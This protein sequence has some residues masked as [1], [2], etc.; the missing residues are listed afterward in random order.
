MEQ[1]VMSHITQQA[2]D[3]C[4]VVIIIVLENCVEIEVVL[5]LS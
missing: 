1:V 3:K 4:V 5:A 2:W